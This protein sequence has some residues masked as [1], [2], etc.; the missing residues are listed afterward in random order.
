M[1]IIVSIRENNTPWKLIHYGDV[2]MGTMA[3]KIITSLVIVY[4]TVYSGA[5]QRKQ[6]S[7]ASLVFV[8]GIHRG[9]MNS[10]HK[11]PVKRKMFPFD[12]VIMYC[13]MT[14]GILA[15][16]ITCASI[17]CSILCSGVHQ[18]N[19]LRVKLRVTGPLWGGSSGDKVPYHDVIMSF[20]IKYQLHVNDKLYLVNTKSINMLSA[21]LTLCRRHRS[22]AKVQW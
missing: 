1:W 20:G 22:P 6:Q 3:S 4:S 15:S 5:D 16:P 2:I 21:S 13:D 8:R 9:P 10:P 7:S 17:V 14:V 11:W 18:R 12:D 19:H